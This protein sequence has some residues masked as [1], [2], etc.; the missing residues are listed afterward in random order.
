MSI[1]QDPIILLSYINTQ[2]RDFYPNLTELC[3]T[4][5]LDEKELRNQLKAIDYEYNA[6]LNQFK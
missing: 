4:L 2:L 3:Q 5:N 6:E 1:P